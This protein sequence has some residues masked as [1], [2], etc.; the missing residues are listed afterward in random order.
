[1]HHQAQ[2]DHIS[3]LA[4]AMTTPREQFEVGISSTQL[5]GTLQSA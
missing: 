2:N 4:L 5:T 1:L 3:D